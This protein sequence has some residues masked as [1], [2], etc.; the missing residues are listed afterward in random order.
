MRMRDLEDTGSRLCRMH[1][2]DPSHPLTL[3]AAPLTGYRR[4]HRHRTHPIQTATRGHGALSVYSGPRALRWTRTPP[5]VPPP[6][7]P[8]PVADDVCR[9]VRHA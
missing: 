7:R 2:G 9:E 8:W 6:Y 3:I 1:G 4:G 5:V